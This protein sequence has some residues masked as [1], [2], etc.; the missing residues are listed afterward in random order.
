MIASPTTQP[1]APYRVILA[2][3][4]WSYEYQTSRHGGARRHY[5]TAGVD[6]IAA[7]L[8]PLLAERGDPRG[9]ALCLWATYPKIEDALALI[10]VL[11]YRYRTALFTWVKLDA[12][13]KP[14]SNG[15]GHYTR[16][17]AEVCL[18]ATRGKRPPRAK[19]H[20]ISSVILTRRREHSRKPDEQYGRLMA[21]FDGPYL[22]LYGRQA[23]PGWDVWGREAGKF[24]AQPFLLDPC[25]DLS[26]VTQ[27]KTA[28]PRAR[29]AV[30]A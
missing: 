16:S 17:N 9:S 26:V 12:H 28:R 15:L 10:T 2:D 18:L 3:P 11:G 24:A 6:E 13:G 7:T 27:A 21:L 22:E 29:R 25:A 30:S 14:I 5:L 1:A 19:A 20:N 23:W 8:A 4:N